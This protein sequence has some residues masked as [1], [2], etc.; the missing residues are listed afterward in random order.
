MYYNPFDEL[1]ISIDQAGGFVNSHAHF[2]RAYT[3]DR[4]SMEDVVYSQLQEKWQLVDEYKSKAT[5]EDYER[6][7][8]TALL[9]QVS[10]NT[11][12]CFSFIDLDPVV[13][14][15]AIKAAN[16]VQAELQDKVMFRYGFQTLKG[17]LKEECKSMIEMSID[18]G[19]VNALGS[20]P[21]AD[22][23]PLLHLEYLIQTIQI[24]RFPCQIA[25]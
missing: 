4:Q 10:M 19:L 3:V 15:R 8:T 22:Y 12:K 11:H 1:L 24:L 18:K 13:G 17:V 25:D 5:Q 9:G 21:A 7:I 6:S 20:L 14:W 2:D 16:K 23:D